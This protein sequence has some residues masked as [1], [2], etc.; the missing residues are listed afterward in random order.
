[1]VLCAITI[2]NNQRWPISNPYRV[3]RM[4][5]IAGFIIYFRVFTSFFSDYG[6][7]ESCLEDRP[8]SLKWPDNWLRQGV[9]SDPYRSSHKIVLSYMHGALCSM[10]H[11]ATHVHVC[12][13]V[14]E[15]PV[16]VFVDERFYKKNLNRWQTQFQTGVYINMHTYKHNIQMYTELPWALYLRMQTLV[17]THIHSTT[18][19]CENMRV[20]VDVFT[21]MHCSTCI[22]TW[23][24]VTHRLIYQHK[25]AIILMYAEL[26]WALYLRMFDINAHVHACIRKKKQTIYTRG[27]CDSDRLTYRQTY[28]DAAFLL[29]HKSSEGMGKDT[30]QKCKPDS[31]VF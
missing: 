3:A 14:C 7:S 30:H 1:M 31:S 4:C 11:T 24:C 29:L 27:V 23:W 2:H 16:L 8:L 20:R 21:D 6:K 17:F 5:C 10:S 25:Y 13:C 19:S 18:H 12:R 28:R 9:V 22:H 15:W 26:S